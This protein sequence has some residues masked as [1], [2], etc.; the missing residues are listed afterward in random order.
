MDYELTD[1]EIKEVERQATEVHKGA[2]MF[3]YHILDRQRG[4]ANAAVAKYQKWQA[5]LAPNEMLA[6]VEK[7]SEL[8]SLSEYDNRPTT[9]KTVDYLHGFIVG[10]IAMGKVGYTHKVLR[11]IGG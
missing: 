10:K 2:Y 1:E 8:P 7:E 6:V 11:K 5:D 9:N 4:I 3:T